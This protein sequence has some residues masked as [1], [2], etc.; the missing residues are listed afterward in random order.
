[1]KGTLGQNNNDFNAGM[2]DSHRQKF[3]FTNYTLD[4]ADVKVGYE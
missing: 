2:E 4:E 3:S 1:M